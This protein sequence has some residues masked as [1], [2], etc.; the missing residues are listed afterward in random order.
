M[1]GRSEADVA[2]DLRVVGDTPA[3]MARYA[4]ELA[5]R[6]PAL[7]PE[8]K[9]SLIAGP[10]AP[11]LPLGPNVDVVRTRSAF[12]SPAEQ[13]EVPRAA[14]GARLLHATTFSV[15]RLR[16][17]A[18]VVTIHDANHL[19]FPEQ[20]GPLQG[21]YYRYIVAPTARRARVLTVSEFARREISQRL[22]LAADGIGVIPNGVD[23]LFRPQDPGDVEAWRAARGLPGRFVLYVGNAKP[24]KNVAALV[25]AFDELPSDVGLVLCGG[26]A[27]LERLTDGAARASEIRVLPQ[28]PE[29]E[30][31]LLYAA[32]ALFC[33]PSRYEGFGLPPLE[34][35]ACGTPVVAARAGALP[36]VLGGAAEFFDPD[37]RT[38]C[39]AALQ[40][41]LTSKALADSLRAA[42]LERARLFSWDHT[43]RQT[44]D[45]YRAML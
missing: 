37:D 34:A 1:A 19:A 30:L 26:G 41:V 39:A 23:D 38:G 29:R 20:Y 3:G 11:P 27:E 14:H 40:Q 31:P 15:P 9:F 6:I 32:A 2:I 25:A 44:L 42:G 5:R 17:G 24:H 4:L 28:I 22:G 16:R 21:P 12:L 18:L 43:A 45:V 10:E 7:A 33:F 35:M 13:L 8:L 36:E